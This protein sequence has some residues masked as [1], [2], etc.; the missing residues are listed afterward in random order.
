MRNLKMARINVN[1]F[2]IA[3][4]SAKMAV[5]ITNKQGGIFG[6]DIAMNFLKMSYYLCSVGEVE[7]FISDVE[8]KTNADKIAR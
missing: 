4:Q 1:F 6:W 7:G 2:N 3:R 5:H 8:K